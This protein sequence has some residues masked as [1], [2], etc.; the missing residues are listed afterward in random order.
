[1]IS[2]FFKT[3]SEIFWTHF[4][5]GAG[6]CLVVVLS[7]LSVRCLSARGGRMSARGGSTFLDYFFGF[8]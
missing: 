6:G 2:H 1:M 7:I 8:L 5:S 4:P 3:D